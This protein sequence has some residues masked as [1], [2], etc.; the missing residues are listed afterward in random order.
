ML[1]SNG[2]KMGN[3]WNP[4]VNYIEKVRIREILEVPL[5]AYLQGMKEEAKKYLVSRYHN[6]KLWLDQPHS[7]FRTTINLITRLPYKEPKVPTT[8][9]VIH[10]LTKLIGGAS[11]KNSRGLVIIQVQEPLA[12]W[13]CTIFSLFLTLAG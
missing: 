6:G 1:I 7:I 9:N 12:R 13:I 2:E 3:Q 5:V 10:W 4:R 8:A 11:R